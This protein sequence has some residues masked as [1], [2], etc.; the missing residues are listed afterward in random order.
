MI[1]VLLSGPEDV[2]AEAI[3]RSVYSNLEPDTPF[4]RAIELKAG[5]TVSGRLE[6]TGDLPIGAAA[7]TPGGDAGPGFLIH[8]VVQSTVE[9]VTADGVRAALKNGLRRAEE[10][11]LESL[12]LPPL[13]TGAGNLEADE[14]AAI[15]IPLLFQ[16]LQDGSALSEV[17]ILVGTSFE[18]DVFTRAIAWHS[19]GDQPE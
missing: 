4:S 7:I 14:V 12:V 6:A 8:V 3:L 5:P 2:K 1:R 11:G 18:E 9:P 13:G 10:W 15:M 17:S 16:H 19:R